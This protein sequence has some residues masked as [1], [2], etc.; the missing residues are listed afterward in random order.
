MLGEG[1]RNRQCRRGAGE[2]AGNGNGSGCRRRMPF[3][4]EQ[5][6]AQAGCGL[7]LKVCRIGGGRG[8][9]ARMA[10]LGIF[11]GQEVELVCAAGQSRCLVRLNGSTVSLGDGVAENILVKA[12]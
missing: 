8:I 2:G 3:A 5:S 1:F 6:L 7:R 12:A 4:G 11:P 10:T 9:C